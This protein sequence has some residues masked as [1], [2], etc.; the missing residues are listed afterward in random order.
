[1]K[2]KLFILGLAVLSII[3]VVLITIQ[4]NKKD[5]NLG[6]IDNLA[7]QEESNIKITEKVD[8][9]SDVSFEITEYEDRVDGQ[10]NI[11]KVEKNK[12]DSKLN[13]LITIKDMYQKEIDNVIAEYQPKI[14]SIN[15]TISQIIK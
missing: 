4:F 12:Y 15:L 9:N 11:I 10:G 1:M 7:L 14:D 6:A 5:N 13:E 3:I 8:E 2:N